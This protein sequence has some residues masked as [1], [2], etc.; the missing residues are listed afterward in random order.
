MLSINRVDALIIEIPI[1][2]LFRGYANSW[3][4]LMNPFSMVVLA[5]SL[6]FFTTEN[7]DCAEHTHH[8]YSG[9]ASEA[10][11][12]KRIHV[13]DLGEIIVKDNMSEEAIAALS[14][15]LLA[16]YKHGKEAYQQGDYKTAYEE[17]SILANMGHHDS[18]MW[19]LEMYIHNQYRPMEKK[20]FYNAERIKRKRGA[21]Q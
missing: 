21:I 19:L 12:Y 6:M 2:M 17:F 4:R 5:I 10:T 1:A 20:P 15:E 18:S 16:R 14:K 11:H 8:V 3:E 9:M 13:H 7:A